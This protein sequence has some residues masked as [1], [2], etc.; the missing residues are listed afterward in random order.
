[1]RAAQVHRLTSTLTPMTGLPCSARHGR[2]GDPRRAPPP[3]TAGPRTVAKARADDTIG[4]AAAAAY[5]TE[6]RR[7]RDAGLGTVDIAAST[8]V[9]T[10]A[11]GS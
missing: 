1:M 11:G 8:G 7:I 2:R 5:A 4:L 10:D 3:R 6:V 9:D